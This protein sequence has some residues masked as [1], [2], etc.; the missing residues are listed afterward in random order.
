MRR[1]FL[2]S[3]ASITVLLG[4]AA[5]SLPA[6]AGQPRPPGTIAPVAIGEDRPIWTAQAPRSDT[7]SGAVRAIDL[8]RPSDVD[9]RRYRSEKATAAWVPRPAG[10]TD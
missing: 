6:T 2:I 9:Q 10:P 4:T 7:Q 8:P 1:S 5:Y 3:V